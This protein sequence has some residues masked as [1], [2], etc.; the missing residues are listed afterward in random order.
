MYHRYCLI[1]VILLTALAASAQKVVESSVMAEDCGA[2]YET[3]LAEYEHAD[4]VFAGK[5]LGLS[6]DRSHVVFE[7]IRSWKGVTSE[8]CEV[9]FS[10]TG[11]CSTYPFVVGRNYLVF[12]F[13][14]RS[15]SGTRTKELLSSALEM[16]QFPNAPI[17]INPKYG[18]A[19]PPGD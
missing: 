18:G 3:L 10:P 9:V 8:S 7:V 14:G 1:A 13:H 5:A 17:Y 4:Q 19:F 15:P 12:A 16:Q 6:Q 11:P 2:Y